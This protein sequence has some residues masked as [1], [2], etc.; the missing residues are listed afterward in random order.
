MIQRAGDAAVAAL[1]LRL[2]SPAVVVP[3]VDGEAV[4]DDVVE[5]VVAS[6]SVE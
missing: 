3:A 4:V 2:A 5:A 6:R 1:A